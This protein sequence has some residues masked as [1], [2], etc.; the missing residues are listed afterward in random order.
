MILEQA[1]YKLQSWYGLSWQSIKVSAIKSWQL[2]A[3]DCS[4]VWSRTWLH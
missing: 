3:W 1:A 2:I 4:R